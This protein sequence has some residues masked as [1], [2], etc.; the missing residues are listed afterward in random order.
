MDQK[1]R[2]NFIYNKF[3]K[4]NN[5][6][7]NYYNN[8]NNNNNNNNINIDNNDENEKRIDKARMIYFKSL[9][10][11]KK[12]LK[13]LSKVKVWSNSQ[14]RWFYGHII[15]I[16][17]NDDQIQLLAKVTW[18]VIDENGNLLDK[19]AEY[20]YKDVLLHQDFIRKPA[21]TLPPIMEE[22]ENDHIT[23]KVSIFLYDTH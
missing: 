11:W 7:I 18:K 22:P 16:F 15:N 6:N 2:N 14:R 12:S 4:R 1:Y 13:I 17:R 20:A 21:S 5:N 8:N 19:Q 3:I 10:E 9:P 23:V